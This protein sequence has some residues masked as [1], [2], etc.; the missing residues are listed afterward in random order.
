MNLQNEK[1]VIAKKWIVSSWKQTELLRSI[2]IVHNIAVLKNHYSTP[3][4]SRIFFLKISVYGVVDASTTLIVYLCSVPPHHQQTKT[5]NNLFIVLQTLVTWGWFSRYN[6]FSCIY[7]KYHTN[8]SA[9]QDTV[10][11]VV[12]QCCPRIKNWNWYKLGLC[13]AKD[14]V[15][16]SN[17]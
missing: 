16:F 6:V 13:F 14:L 7:T 5:D 1:R 12:L 9:K 17:N 8:G 2:R 3:L 4:F 10:I 15:P 11:V